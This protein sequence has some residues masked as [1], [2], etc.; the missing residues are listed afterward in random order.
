MGGRCFG[1]DVIAG[2]KVWSKWSGE[3]HA[4]TPVS[5]KCNRQIRPRSDSPPLR[6]SSL[7]DDSDTFNRLESFSSTETDARMFSRPGS[8]H[9][10]AS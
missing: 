4:W 3:D 8:S 7:L 5:E 9:G 6:F 1:S 10:R 2:T